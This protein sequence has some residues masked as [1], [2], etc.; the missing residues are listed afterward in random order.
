MSNNRCDQRKLHKKPKNTWTPTRQC[1]ELK[2][3]DGAFWNRPSYQIYA[4][5]NMNRFGGIV[6]PR[7]VNRSSPVQV[8]QSVDNWIAVSQQA[9]PTGLWLGSMIILYGPGVIMETED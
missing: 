5:G 2:R 9:V 4:T 6:T 1:A 3:Q 8:S 7:G